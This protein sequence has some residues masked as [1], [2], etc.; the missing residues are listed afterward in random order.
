MGTSADVLRE[1]SDLPPGLEG[2]RGSIVIE[3][4]RSQSLTAKQLSEALALS[5]NAIRHHLKELEAAGL[6]RHQ[7]EARGGVGAPVFGYRLT[8]AG[9]DLFPRRYEE[10]LTSLLDHLVEGLG[11]DQAVAALGARYQNLARRLSGDL[12]RLPARQR[13][14]RVGEVLT[15]EGYMAEWSDGD[16]DEGRMVLTEHNCAMGSVARKFPE[17][18]EAE[19]RFLGRVLGAEVERRS[20]MLD[21]CATCQ[22][23]VDFGRDSS[24]TEETR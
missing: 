10:A 14:E 22:Y 2:P 6:V 18:C 5:P 9:H 12:E 24:P 4:K 11:R 3:L 21:G 16:G 8:R 1:I 23:H 13:L 15:A 19:R 7:R 20:H 17:I